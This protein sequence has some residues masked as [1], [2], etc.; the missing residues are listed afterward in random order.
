MF[1]SFTEFARDFEDREIERSFVL[2]LT[3]GTNLRLPIYESNPIIPRPC[4]SALNRIVHDLNLISC[5]PIPGKFLHRVIAILSGKI[6]PGIQQKNRPHYCRNWNRNGQW[7]LWPN[8]DHKTTYSSDQNKGAH[9]KP[10]GGMLVI[11]HRIQ[12][13][14]EVF[15]PCHKSQSKTRKERHK[16][17]ART[18]L[19]FRGSLKWFLTP[20]D[21]SCHVKSRKH[22][23]GAQNES[24]KSI[25]LVHLHVAMC[26]AIPIVNETVS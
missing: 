4:P 15:M 25:L 23:N 21:P 2:V 16:P 19:R 24:Y 11:Q 12:C 17:P 9:A 6:F 7:Y 8:H 22:V 5:R 18:L 13:F 10:N 14:I 20:S 3:N 26:V 1:R